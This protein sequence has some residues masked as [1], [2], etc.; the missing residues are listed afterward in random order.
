MSS[1]Q[2][3]IHERLLRRTAQQL[4]HNDFYQ[5][6]YEKIF[7]EH[8]TAKSTR[9]RLERLAQIES[10]CDRSSKEASDAVKVYMLLKEHAKQTKITN[11]CTPDLDETNDNCLEKMYDLRDKIEQNASAVQE[12]NELLN[13]IEDSK[14]LNQNSDQL[15]E[16]ITDKALPTP[17]TTLGENESRKFNS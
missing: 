5:S 4:P 11:G 1:E 8:E 14:N 6:N 17:P 12:F 16:F 9:I 15:L 10:N 2:E 13:A 3:K 7:R